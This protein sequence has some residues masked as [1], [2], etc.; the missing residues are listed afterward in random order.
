[1]H[2]SGDAR[3]PSSTANHTNTRKM[4]SIAVMATQTASRPQC[5]RCPVLQVRLRGRCPGIGSARTSR[6]A[7][8]ADSAH[9]GTTL[10]RTERSN[11]SRRVAPNP[12]KRLRSWCQAGTAPRPPT[13][14]HLCIPVAL[15]R[16]RNH[17]EAPH[18]FEGVAERRR[19]QVYHG[20]SEG[21]R[22]CHAEDD[23]HAEA[24]P[25]LAATGTGT[26]APGACT[27]PP[28]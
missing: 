27:S 19:T 2:G 10:R 25:R 3:L 1:M 12:V 20:N 4:P 13:E 14:M 16:E 28:R 17:I 9:P 5:H 24:E 18:S 8:T 7:S 6:T 15:V 22:H 11:R 26:G 23:R 21:R